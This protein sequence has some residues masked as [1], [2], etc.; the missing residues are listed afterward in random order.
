LESVLSHTSSFHIQQ[1]P[2][3]FSYIHGT[4]PEPVRKYQCDRKARTMAGQPAQILHLEK[5]LTMTRSVLTSMVLGASLLSGAAM[6]AETP[7]SVSAPVPFTNAKLV[8][9]DLRNDTA[10]AIKVQAG[11]IELTLRPGYT[12]DVKLPV[13]LNVVAESAT[14]ERAAGSVLVQVAEALAGSTVEIK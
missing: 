8:H 1:N 4:I 11:A 9:F 12:V 10:A 6:H 13:G 5:E 2:C 14:P 3:N 7:T